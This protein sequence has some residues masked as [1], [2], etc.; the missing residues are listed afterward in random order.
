MVE[1][2]PEMNAYWIVAIS[3]LLTQAT[4]L[5]AL[6]VTLQRGKRLKNIENHMAEMSPF[7]K[8]FQTK[9][10]SKLHHPHIDSQELDQLLEKLE[11]LTL[12]KEERKKLISLLREITDDPHSED[13]ELA[14]FL[15][16]AMPRVAK[17]RGDPVTPPIGV[18]V[19]KIKNLPRTKRSDSVHPSADK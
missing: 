13:Q 14:H 5:L 18:P 10:V 17:E 19:R 7:W 15:L 4:L 2:L 6:L 16:F 8:T 11:A 1:E 3:L 12:S 9:V